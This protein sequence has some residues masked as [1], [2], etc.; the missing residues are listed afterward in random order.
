MELV[1]GMVRSLAGARSRPRLALASLTL[2]FS[3][4]LSGAPLAVYSDQLQNG[5]ADWS[6][7]AHSLS[8]TT[9]VHSGSAAI[10]FEPSGYGGLYLERDA[11]IDLSTYEALDFWIHGGPSGGQNVRLAALVAGKIS[12]DAAVSGFIPG[13]RIP[14][15]QWVQ[16]HVPFASLGT[17][18]GVLSGFWFMDG[19][20]GTQ[21]PV[22]LDDIQITQRTTPPPVGAAVTVAVDPAA[23]RHAVSPLIY[24]VSFGTAAQLSRLKFPVRRWGGNGAT[25]Y[26]WQTDTQNSA[27]DWFYINYAQDNANPGALPAGST[28]DVFID[29]ARA[30]GSEPL[31]TVPLI[32]WTPVDRV[33]RW[34]F[35]VA[36]YGAQQQT[37][38]D[39]AGGAFWCNPDAGNGVRPDGVTR[40]TGNDPHDT[41]KEVGTSFVTD[42]MKHIASRVG[43]AGAGGVRF[44][45][46]DNEPGIWSSTHRDVHP[47][48]ATY[49]ELWQK[50]RDYAAA[51]KAQDPG[52][53]LLGPVSWGWCE[54][55]FSDADN[56][57]DGPDRQAHGGLPWLA[58][59]LKQVNDTRQ[60]T[61]VRLIDYLD[62]HAYP[63]A[64]NVA[65]SDDES[66][67]TSALRLRSVKGLYDPT[68][69]DESWVAQPVNLIPRLKAWIDQYCP[70][71]KLAITE[72]SWGGDK[73]LSST[74]AQA[75]VL[76]IFGREG[77]DLANRWTA[78]EDRSL[79]EDAFKL[80]L[81]YDG[82]GSR[83]GSES[84]QAVS[85]DV[86]AVG[87]Y[88]LRDS[89]RVYVLL[90]NKD[91]A[92]RDA[93]VSIAGSTGTSAALYRVQASSRLG[94]SGTVP[95][96]RGA[97]A[98]SLPARS[99][100]LAVIGGG[101]AGS[102]GNTR[103][104]T[105]ATAST[106]AGTQGCL[107][108]SLANSATPSIASF[109]ADLIYDGASLTPASV[110]TS[111]S[112]KAAQGSVTSSGVYRVTVSGG[113]GALPNGPS[114]SVCF[115]TAAGKCGSFTV[116][117][118]AGTPTASD[119]NAAPVGVSGAAGALAVTGCDGAGGSART[120]FL[121]SS[122][123][124]VGA[125]G[126][127][128]HT[129]LRLMN[130][131]PSAVTVTP[132][133]YDQTSGQAYPAAPFA[134]AGRSQVSY[135]NV[136]QSLFGRGPGAY[137][138]IRLQTSGPL[139]VSSVVN[140][141]NAC[142]AGAVSGE[143]LP[144][145]DASQAMTAG[146]LVQ[147][148]LSADGG[149]G[150]RT[151]VVFVNPGTQAATVSAGLRRG[152]GS[153]I[154]TSSIGPLPANGFRQVSLGGFPGAA[155]VTDTNLFLEFT[156]D[157]PVLA[158]ASVINNG[159]GD[160]FAIVASPDTAR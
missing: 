6:W 157:Q 3:W 159:S 134:V 17:P 70:G 151:N 107:E 118:G 137:G 80:Y 103:L 117:F 123:Y 2:I 101:P 75:E 33:R 125:G 43:T 20:G 10:S 121:P 68:Y 136:L 79:V 143:W 114:A 41:S 25:R 88:A 91:T 63:Y 14:A 140:N 132:T 92:A 62:V 89:T 55:F 51:I 8:Q 13:G 87:A 39:A 31:I 142:G 139:I 36:K 131:G 60:A 85:S 77:V 23:G 34:G 73:G 1:S 46:L 5:F 49:D 106:A 153:S 149:T 86:D 66:A 113:N 144:G 100:T 155:G 28:A 74:L 154:G 156:S 104:F 71:T 90:F 129:D 122:A 126:A 21:A 112:G 12:G 96:V 59:Y 24:G 98:V 84:V 15:G 64:N 53:Q 69:T 67:A 81:D 147:L 16:V 133:L 138:P 152:A 26:N 32:G 115:A 148:A 110:T 18:S 145:L 97:L 56:C 158:F 65:L 19:S 42:W 27:N 82:N 105:V 95:V 78:P 109:S 83:V 7:A 35:S 116:G 54:Y 44:F 30:A 72:Y 37:E 52:A 47:Q 128:F 76:A 40:V 102:G 108:I 29:E 4:G 38:C 93:A 135:D 11:G 99:A 150:Y 57:A 94:A 141:V 130:P 61:G 22:Y 9:V 45:A 120:Y 160:P 50:T 124:S 58:W 119:G 111:V 146:I 127:E 48:K